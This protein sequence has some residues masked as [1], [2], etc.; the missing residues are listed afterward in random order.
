[1]KTI[2]PEGGRPAEAAASDHALYRSF[3]T[4]ETAR[5]RRR[6]S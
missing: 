6:T 5:R 2:F 4:F 1:M 3:F